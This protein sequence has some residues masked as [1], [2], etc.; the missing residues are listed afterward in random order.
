MKS[1]T[2]SAAAAAVAA[3]L[4]VCP[5]F[6]ADSMNVV[7]AKAVYS[8]GAK[9]D[10]LA[11]RHMTAT[12]ADCVTCHTDNKVSDSQTEIDVNC[13]KCHGSYES[14][15]K[16][17]SA[18]AGHLSINS[19]TTCHGGHEAS[20][21]YC[22]NCHV[23]DMNMKF[24]RQKIP[25][26][27][28]DLGIYKDAVPN[29]T[30]AADL[31]IVGG[32]GAGMAAAI[33]GAR[34]GM[35]VVLLEKMPIIGGSSLLSTGGM[36]VTGSAQQKAAGIK[37]STETFIKDTLHVG[38]GKNDQSLLRV[39]G[40]HS[41]EALEWFEKLGGELKLDPGV[42]GGCSAARMHFTPTGGIGK[43]MVRY[44]K[45]ALEKSGADVRLNSQVVRL[46]KDADGRVTG[47]LI[48][49][50]N[51]GLYRINARAVVLTTGSYANNGEIVSKYH[52]EFFGMVT[53]AQPGSHGDGIFLGKAAG[54][55]VNH[56]ERV[57]VHPNIAS[58]TSLMITLAMRTNGGILVNN[59][60]KRF[61]NDNAPRNEL[62]AAMLKQPAQKVWLIYD[63]AVVA[64]RAKV[65]HGYETLGLVTEA[66]SAEALAEK[67]GLPA[68]AFADTMKRYAGFVKN[69]KDEDF[70]RKELPEPL[71][72]GKLYAIDV[73]PAIGGTLGGLRTDTSTRVLDE[74]GAPI[75]GLFAAGEVVGDWHGE[76]RYGGNAVTGN[77]VFG[78]MAAQQAK[79]LMK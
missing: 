33:E 14:L 19:C 68:K 57:Q 58:G 10:Y 34:L 41:S 64:K 17:I 79:S 75:P 47:V 23:F 69:G 76:D 52:P 67:L 28:Q 71:N 55:Q 37:D 30:E 70:G 12:G 13:Q 61:F 46:E 25:Y 20:F 27:P 51:T 59:Q 48:K 18:H 40:D 36:N 63:D 32:G 2:V 39:L 45:P 60:G 74:K 31:V 24:G 73:V 49:G 29:R 6:A 21:A 4:A 43:Y 72:Q 26:V 3:A 66:D 50:K 42:Y 77:I 44:M 35:K 62:G 7:S 8:Q 65:H 15:G 1:L 9:S 53:S 54:A 11:G 22:N 56:L 38:K 78:R 5:V 16:K